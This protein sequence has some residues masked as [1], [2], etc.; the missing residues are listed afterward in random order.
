MS[1]L[2]L[3]ASDCS[4]PC[5]W[6]WALHELDEDGRRNALLAEHD[7]TLD[8]NDWQFAAWLDLDRYLSV[9][10]RPDHRAEDQRRIAAD[11]GDWIGERVFG[12]VGERLAELAG[13]EPLMV[14]ATVESDS[15]KPEDAAG[16][17]HVLFRPLELATIGGKPLALHDVSLI[18]DTRPIEPD[19]RR[20]ARGIAPA[21]QSLRMLCVFSLPSGVG[22]LNLRHERYQLRKLIRDLTTSQSLDVEL[23]VVQYGV[24]RASLQKILREGGGWDIVHFSGHGLESRLIL[25]QEDGSRDDVPTEEL[26][27]LL[28]ATKQRLKW[29]TLSAAAL[30]KTRAAPGEVGT[31]TN[32]SSAYSCFSQMYVKKSPSR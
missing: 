13:D 24:T 21:T 28:R 14:Y 8:Q 15:D 32:E 10:A 30:A 4:G 1:L 5:R 19:G 29:V 20:R 6:H 12:P 7:V 27:K 31:S 23:R 3:T 11:V 18:F 2:A 9:T 16:D 22:A 26:V 17:E 25:E